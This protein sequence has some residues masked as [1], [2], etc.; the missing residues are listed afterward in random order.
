MQK[1]RPQVLFPNW[2]PRSREPHEENV[3]VYSNC[4]R[5][6]LFL[7]GKSL[8]AKPRPA[9]DSPRNWKV[10]FEPGTLRAVA[11][12]GGQV[13]ATH[14]LRTAGKPARV[15][16]SA[17]RTRLSPTW[18]DVSYVEAKVV[19]ADGVIVPDAADLIAFKVTGPGRVIAVDSANNASRE[20]FQSS[21]RR[22]YQGRCF[23]MIKADAPRGRITVVASAAGLTGGSVTVEAVALSATKAARS[24]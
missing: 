21:E 17:D 15:L 9:D 12:N 20:P 23:A 3:E 13:V 1:R 7:N 18:D 10:P 16:L 19:D 11:T 2:T 5:V 24:R 6:E 4:E 8:G 14:E 22:V